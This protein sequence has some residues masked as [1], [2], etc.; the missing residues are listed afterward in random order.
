MENQCMRKKLMDE[1]KIND[2]CAYRTRKPSYVH[3]STEQRTERSISM[4]DKPLFPINSLTWMLT[5][6]NFF[7]VQ[8]T[9]INNSSIHVLYILLYYS[10]M[11]FFYELK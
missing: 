9:K 2:L 3:Y 6:R 11:I 10:I 1:E 7:T 8:Y 5:F 4:Q